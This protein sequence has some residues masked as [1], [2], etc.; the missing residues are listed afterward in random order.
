MHGILLFNNMTLSEMVNIHSFRQRIVVLLLL[1]LWQ[2]H[3]SP[4]K[5]EPDSL[6]RSSEVLTM[7][8]RTDFRAI[9]NNRTEDAE[10]QNGEI[11]YTGSGNKVVAIPVRVSPRGKFRLKPENCSFPP[12]LLNFRKEDVR[13]TLFEKQDKLKLVTPCREEKEV[14]EEYTIYKMYQK[15]TDLSLKVRLVVINY[16]D[17]ATDSLILSGHSFFTEDKERAAERLNATLAGKSVTPYDL[18]HDSFKKLA[19]F[20]YMIGNKDWYVTSGHNIIIMEPDDKSGKPF[21]VPYDFDFSGMINAAYTKA[22]GSPS[23]PSSARRQ[24]KGL[25]YTMEELRDAF[26]FFRNLRPEFSNL[27]KESEL[28]PKSDKNEMLNYIAYFYS[29]SRSRFMIREEIIN[30]CET[31]AL[32]NIT[33]Q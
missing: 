24:Y 7:E 23:E 9:L 10:Y 15:V 11:R 31:K 25:C 17:A 2:A 32:Y 21:A 18:D 22:K 3:Q 20:Q 28:I 30:K 1:S 5:G 26:V 12:L 8:L 14:I 29:L 4:L 13:N 19:L 16:I 6:F 27:I 33:G